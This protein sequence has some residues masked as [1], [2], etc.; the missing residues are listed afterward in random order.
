[1]NF[2]HIQSPI[3]T[4]LTVFIVFCALISSIGCTR[5]AQEPENKTTLTKVEEKKHWTCPMHPHVHSNEP[6]K[7][8]ICGM[9]LV[10]VDK[11]I[12]KD[13]SEP[14]RDE[15]SGLEASAVQFRNANI[16]RHIVA[17]KDFVLTLALSG[18]LVSS[19]EVAFQIYES[20]IPLIKPGLEITGYASSNPGILIKGK[21]VGLDNLVDPSSRTLRGTA[22]LNAPLVGFVAETS[23]HG[24]IQNTLKNQLVIP[25]EAVLHTGTRDLV[26][27]FSQNSKLNPRE[28]VLGHKSNFEYQV[29]SGLKE[30]DTIS[31]GANFLIDSEAK[32]RGQ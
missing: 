2:R 27:V 22:I 29:L 19:R 21:V 23:F 30:G 9:P 7:C 18:R 5:K 17:K 15:T 16:T 11:E 31:G 26:Y 10:L 28:V 3:W 25:E 6:G 24:K 12:R 8:P 14:S 13:K 4:V 20:D 1:M 32:I